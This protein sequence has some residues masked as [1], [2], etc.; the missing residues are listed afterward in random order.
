VLQWY[1]C[2]SVSLAFSSSSRKK[3]AEPSGEVCTDVG[4]LSNDK[5][6]GL[7]EMSPDSANYKT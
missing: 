4:S 7:V 5:D 1:V 3:T 2:I 6:A